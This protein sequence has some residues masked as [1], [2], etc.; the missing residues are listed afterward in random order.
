MSEQISSISFSDECEA[1]IHRARGLQVVD[2]GTAARAAEIILAG[3]EIVK[4]IKDFFTPLKRA[5]DAAKQKLISAERSELLKV[6]PIVATASGLLAAWRL[7]EAVKREEAE[8]ARRRQEEERRRLAEKLEQ[9]EKA[10][11][12]EQDRILEETAVLEMSLPPAP[13]V[14][15]EPV[16]NE[17]LALRTH[18]RAVVVDLRALAGAVAGG[19]V[20][21]EALEPNMPYLNRLAS[22]HR[23]QAVIPGVRFQKESSLVKTR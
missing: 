22:A 12:E 19:Q 20:S 6:E 2:E 13:A 3:K 10:P 11:P 17:G 1:L 16:S 9:A 15:P 23:G 5:Q 8:A 21:Q 14:V 18:W 7:A 4:Q